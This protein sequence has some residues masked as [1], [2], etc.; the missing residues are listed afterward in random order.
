MRKKTINQIKEKVISSYS[1]IAHEFDQTRKI[2]WG[3]FNHFLAH[4]KHGGKVLDLGCGNGRFYEFIK[5]KDVDYLGIDN[6]S[7]LLEHARNNFPEATFQLDDMI[8]FSLPE[9]AFDNIFC[10]AAFHHIPSKRLRIESAELIRRSIKTDGILILTVWNLF[11]VKYLKTFL[12]SIFSSIIHLGLKNAWNDL[13]VKWG[14]Y[15]IKR[16]YHAFLPKELLKCFPSDKWKIEELYF[17]RKGKRVS[18]L[19]SFNIVLVAR[20]T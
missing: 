13:W 8:N 2:P 11:Q 7:N 20:K 9:E 12:K 3:E 16:Y 5:Q 10:I 19:R 18:F 6:N 4:T 14:K 15:P 1:A 17:T